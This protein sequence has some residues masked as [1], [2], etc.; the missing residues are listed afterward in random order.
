[1]AITIEELAARLNAEASRRGTTSQALLDELAAKLADDPLEA[2]IG[3]GASGLV[4]PFDIH[5]AR[6]EAAAKKNAQSI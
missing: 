1:M 2:F 5:R 6:A 3:C 4:E